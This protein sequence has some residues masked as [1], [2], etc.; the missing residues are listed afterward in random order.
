MMAILQ[1]NK[2]IG[3]ERVKNV[4]GHAFENGTLGHAYLFSGERGTGKFAAAVDLAMALLCQHKETRPCGE[5]LSCR[6]V[7]SYSHPDFHVI[8]PLALQS[9]HKKD[10]GVLTDEGW[11]FAA[12]AT[13]RRINDPYRLPQYGSAPNIPVDWI[14]EANDAVMRGGTEGP[15]NAV[16]ID[17]VD[18]M[19]HQSA[20]AML[21][22]LE[23]PPAG[24]VMILLTDKQHAVLP[25]IVSRCQ[26]MRF[27]LLPPDVIR[28][29]LYKR[30]RAGT[31]GV[32]VNAV[33]TEDDVET[34]IYIEK[35]KGRNKGKADDAA[36]DL[37]GG[38]DD[39]FAGLDAGGGAGADT[40]VNAD[41]DTDTG[42]DAPIAADP[43]IETA[44]A[45]GSLGAAIEEFEDPREEY[46][47]AAAALWNDSLRGDWDAA[48]R[49]AE[50]LAGGE[51]E[52][53]SSSKTLKCLIHLLRFAF[54]RKFGAPINYINLGVSYQIGL[55]ET[56]TPNDIEG[57]VKRCQRALGDLKSRGNPMLVMVNFACTLMEMLNVE[58]Q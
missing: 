55:P 41:T 10:G 30:S 23:E 11:A 24:T 4:V 21:K 25:T 14:R 38:S 13:K 54:F 17:G 35:G 2:L 43:R 37:F 57:F 18:T 15:A 32:P 20:N 50:R 33:E 52:L 36:L 22:T 47:E 40:D 34:I 31:I 49:A 1:W 19:S 45:C 3:Q 27:A 9:E 39:L 56:V 28:A 58:E 44:S 6:K 16:I 46:Y 51:D 53:S 7:G 12:A 48:A 5:C 42:A 26:M 29:E 8:M